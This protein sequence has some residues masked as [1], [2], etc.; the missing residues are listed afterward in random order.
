M[1]TDLGSEQQLLAC[2]SALIETIKVASGA[3]SKQSIRAPTNTG[4]QQFIFLVDLTALI[5]RGAVGREF[6][7]KSE[8]VYQLHGNNGILGKRRILGWNLVWWIGH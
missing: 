2:S 8:P 7:H 4:Y 1:A 3:S 6:F 5:P